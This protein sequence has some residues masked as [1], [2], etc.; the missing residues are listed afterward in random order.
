M[1]FLFKVILIVIFTLG[2][3]ESRANTLLDSSSKL[4][5]PGIHCFKMLGSL[6][7]FHTFSLFTLSL[8]DPESFIIKK[9]V[10]NKFYNERHYKKGI[11]ISRF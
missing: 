10:Y 9:I 2:I 11:A 8:Y 3:N 7:A 6:S 1:K 5:H 4:S